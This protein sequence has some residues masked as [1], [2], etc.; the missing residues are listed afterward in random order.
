MGCIR[1]IETCFALLYI[2]HVRSSGPRFPAC[3]HKEYGRQRSD[4]GK[5]EVTRSVW[6]TVTG[7]S[8]F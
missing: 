7:K 1:A 6:A 5:R 2:V 3:R 8:M 4:H